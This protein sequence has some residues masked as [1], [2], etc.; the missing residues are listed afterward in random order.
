MKLFRNK[1]HR[2]SKLELIVY[3]R[4]DSG[5][6][7]MGKPAKAHKQVILEECCPLKAKVV[8]LRPNKFEWTLMV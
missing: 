4:K 6:D 3:A 7:R 2:I 1:C 8:G 5:W